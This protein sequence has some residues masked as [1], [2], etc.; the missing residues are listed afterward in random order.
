MG[1]PNESSKRNRNYL[2]DRE[3]D[4]FDQYVPRR[5]KDDEEDDNEK[6]E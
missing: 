6:D 3:L 2:T 1:R 5:V 4:W